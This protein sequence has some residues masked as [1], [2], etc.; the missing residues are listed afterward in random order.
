MPVDADRR[1]TREAH[2]VGVGFRPHVGDPHLGVDPFLPQDGAHP[3]Q[4][5]LVG[6]T[7]FPIQKVN[8]HAA[9]IIDGD[10]AGGREG[11][12][13]I[14]DVHS[15]WFRLH[16]V[17]RYRARTAVERWQIQDRLRLRL[18]RIAPGRQPRFY[19]TAAGA[20]AFAVWTGVRPQT[21]LV[22]ALRRIDDPDGA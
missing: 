13:P 8:A 17:T 7:P 3:L 11:T 22:A 12:S 20:L 5:L 18:R 6:G 15:T 4:G 9:F 19:E 1:R 21:G 14:A 2:G 16:I 10:P